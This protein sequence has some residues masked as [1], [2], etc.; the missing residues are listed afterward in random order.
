MHILPT[1]IY[2]HI[3][4]Y[5]ILR[6]AGGGGLPSPLLPLHEPRARHIAIPAGR[7]EGPARAHHPPATDA[8]GGRPGRPRPPGRHHARH[9]PGRREGRWTAAAP[10]AKGIRRSGLSIDIVNE[11]DVEIPRHSESSDYQ[12]WLHFSRL[13]AVWRLSQPRAADSSAPPDHRGYFWRSRSWRPLR[14]PCCLDSKCVRLS[15]SSEGAGA[16]RQIPQAMQYFPEPHQLLL[17]PIESSLRTPSELPHVA[18][19]ASNDFLGT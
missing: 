18:S 5:L 1:T 19:K 15:E 16:G 4:P 6:L 2:Y 7:P 17:K 12:R 8:R 14:L 9:A 3:I 13:M 11:V 10:H